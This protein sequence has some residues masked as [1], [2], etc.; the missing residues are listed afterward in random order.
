MAIFRVREKETKREVE[1]LPSGGCG[2]VSQQEY[3]CV[4][5]LQQTGCHINTLKV[6][7]LVQWGIHFYL[8]S[9]KLLF[10]QARCDIF[11]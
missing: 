1:I 3:S 6:F 8:S 11:F 10:H 4:C 2:Q 5:V 7:N 9:L